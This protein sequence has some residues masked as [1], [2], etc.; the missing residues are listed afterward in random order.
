MNQVWL[1]VQ[2]IKLLYEGLRQIIHLRPK[3]TGFVQLNARQE[4]SEVLPPRH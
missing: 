1:E 4:R 3:Y 2:W